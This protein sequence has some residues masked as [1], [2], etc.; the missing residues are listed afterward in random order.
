MIQH[1][2]VQPLQLIALQVPRTSEQLRVRP[3]VDI[4]IVDSTEL[5]N[6]KWT[7]ELGI[8]S[9]NQSYSASVRGSGRCRDVG[10]E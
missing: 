1:P 2:T 10:R 7:E 3:L 6:R 4:S 8:L 9:A 5:S